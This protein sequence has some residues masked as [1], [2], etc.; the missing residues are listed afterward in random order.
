MSE[1]KNVVDKVMN[2]KYAKRKLKQ[3][4]LLELDEHTMA[5]INELERERHTRTRTRT[6]THAGWG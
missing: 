5:K 2:I 6:G 3:T 1:P 4:L